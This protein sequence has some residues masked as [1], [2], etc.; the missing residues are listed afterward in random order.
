MKQRLSGFLGSCE[1][2][3]EE[4]IGYRRLSLSHELGERSTCM[5]KWI[6]IRREVLRALRFGSACGMVVW[7]HLAS[8]L[9][10]AE[11]VPSVRWVP[12]PLGTAA[13]LAVDVDG[14]VGSLPVFSVERS[15]NLILWEPW[16]VSRAIPFQIPVPIE[17]SRATAAFY[18]VS[19][20]EPVDSD[21]WA[22][23]ISLPAKL[24]A[25]TGTCNQNNQIFWIK[26]ILVLGEPL[27]IYFQDS[28]RYLLHYDFARARLPGY[29]NVTPAEFNALSLTR[30]GQK[31][32]LGT[33]IYSQPAGQGIN[34]QTPLEFGI[35][36]MGQEPY[37]A[38]EVIRWIRWVTSHLNVPQGSR[39][40]YL[41]AYEQIG[42]AA[43]NQEALLKA[44]IEVSSIE[45]WMIA[46]D[47]CYAP[48]WAVGRLSWVPAEELNSAYAS[49][50]LRADDVLLTS[51]VPSEIPFVAGI[52]TLAPAT[53]NSHP[54]LLAQSYGIPF[55]YL[56]DVD[57]RT[58]VQSLV[59]QT[60]LFRTGNTLSECQ[61]TILPV[62]G[63]LN[64]NVVDAIQAIKTPAPLQI[65]VKEKSGIMVTDPVRLTPDDTRYFGGKASQFGFLRRKIPNQ[66]PPALAF[67]FDLW[68]E[69][70]DQT[71]PSGG[72]LR[73]W[74]RQKLEKYSYPPDMTS[75]R[76]DLAAVRDIINGVA[77]FSDVRKAYIMEALGVF[78]PRHNIRFR[79]S[80]NVEDTERFSGAGLYDS[81]SGC[82]QDDLDNDTAGPSACDATEKSERGVFRA[83]QKVY[84]SFYNDNAF[85][86]RLQY[87][88]PEDSAGMGLLVHLSTPDD[89]EF[90]NGVATM[91]VQKAGDALI[92][93]GKLSTQSGAVSVTNPNLGVLPEVVRFSTGV[94]TNL[95]FES[96]STL[97]PFGS[98]VFAQ[99]AD[100]LALV[101]LLR[102]VAVGYSE[103]LT[104]K[105]RFQ[106][107][108]EYKLEAGLGL[109]LKQ[110]RELPST[111]LSA[112]SPVVLLDQPTR[113]WISG[114]AFSVHR[115]KSEWNLAIQSRPIGTNAWDTRLYRSRSAHFFN[116]ADVVPVLGDPAS[117]GDPTQS[118]LNPDPSTVWVLNR[119]ARNS[120]TGKAR[121]TLLTQVPKV[122]PSTVSAVQLLSDL[123]LKLIVDFPGTVPIPSSDGSTLYVSS[124][125]VRLFP[126]PETQTAD[127]AGAEQFETRGIR[128]NTAFQ[129]MRSEGVQS[130]ANLCTDAGIGTGKAPY[131]F[132][133][134]GNQTTLFGLI[135]TPI[136]LLSQA[137]QTYLLH[138]REGHE[139]VE[140]L[141]C[142]PGLE[143]DLPVSQRQELELKNIRAIYFYRF[144]FGSTDEKT[145]ILGFDD[146][147]REP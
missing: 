5:P 78:P 16:V 109:A 94:T 18:R 64:S 69:F 142:E 81:F 31:L 75:L 114:D 143:P 59:G 68:D 102:Q 36:L 113:Y 96:G 42:A 71:L 139:T 87:R 34:D 12:S 1:L 99:D 54:I 37:S 124:N 22:N 52:V 123:S 104:N 44:G 88:V 45:H 51:G 91:T 60:V 125:T 85:L 8:R 57:E 49:G 120:A 141:I 30:A 92:C 14:P 70:L 50:R 89:E 9:Q 58:R 7:I 115:L 3:G 65:P 121:V 47:T 77:Q 66:S 43:S 55:I 105:S 23:V 46:S 19:S 135:S 117:W 39:A 128:A 137:S 93:D 86:Q 101:E 140:E 24:F 131:T 32:V 79:S 80:T 138:G 6:D 2:P 98:H 108:F 136:V 74:I 118:I 72:T 28:I 133:S 147:F 76:A 4:D 41:P 127:I 144:Q 73:A 112:T 129:L 100:Y 130:T 35:Q 67:S 107:D 95:V 38:E 29:A 132:V 25:N 40:L 110:V 84:A 126:Y 53:P 63:V 20:R 15:S 90:A 26:F 17:S 21:D 122:V 61:S 116:G 83:I 145:W 103:W 97:V 11:S 33:V 56:S 146:L 134:V 27:Q 48:G 82:L 106:L 62:D 13:Q 10:G 119:W 111:D